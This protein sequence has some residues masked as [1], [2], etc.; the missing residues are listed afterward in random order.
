MKSKELKIN[1]LEFIL[2]AKLIN[3]F[4]EINHVISD[5]FLELHRKS[6]PIYKMTFINLG[7]TP[8][9]LSF[10][11]A[12]KV[13]ENIIV[14]DVHD[15]YVREIKNGE[16]V[17]GSYEFVPM[18]KNPWCEDI[19]YINNLHEII[20]S[21]KDHPVWTKNRAE[22]SIGK[23]VQKIFPNKYKINVK[24]EEREL[25]PKP[26]DIES[27]VN[28][29]IATVE[30][31]SKKIIEVKGE[32]IRHFYYHQNY[33]KQSGSLGGS[34]MRRSETQN[35]L[36]IYCLNPDQVSM[37]VLFPEDE[38]NKIIGRALLWNLDEPQRRFMDRIYTANDSDLYL[39]T[40]YAKK[41]GYI[42]RDLQTFGYNGNFKDGDK[43]IGN[44][45]MSVTLSHKKYNHFPYVD[46]LQ[47]MD[48]KNGVMTNNIKLKEN[49]GNRFVVLN[50]VDGNYRN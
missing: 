15:T 29:F 43:N 16:W 21:E 6:D 41:N 39:F 14:D 31:H 45:S 37:L 30:S 3:I 38:R 13:P 11:Q 7:S 1:D 34:C 25:L 10:I 40:E 35:F 8:D 50:S 42:Y 44:I 24:K 49:S 22:I 47:F 4:K 23:F 32:Q 2:S 18:Y 36:D 26:N 27:F 5:D 19:N 28:M 20:F 9:S 12:N 33:L 48:I 17:G 46:T